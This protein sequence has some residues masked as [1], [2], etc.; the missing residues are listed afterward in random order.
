MEII[1]LML[2][3]WLAAET[4]KLVFPE[5]IGTPTSRELMSSGQFIAGFKRWSRQCGW[6]L[7]ILIGFGAYLPDQK[8]LGFVYLGML[9]FMW[10]GWAALCK[11]GLAPKQ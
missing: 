1:W 9:I 8:T 3:M 10:L 4:P 7:L 6:Y 11:S 5:P 2:G